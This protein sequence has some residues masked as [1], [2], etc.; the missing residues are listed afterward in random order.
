MRPWLLRALSVALALAAGC[1]QP[2]PVVA[3]P[4]AAG[5]G[6]LFTYPRDGQLDVPAGAWVVLHFS[7][8]LSAGAFDAGCTRGDAGVVGA[9][10]VEGPSGLIGS[11]ATLTGSSIVFAPSG[12]LEPGATYRIHAGPT[13]LEGATNLPAAGPLLTFH[14]RH[15]RTVGGDAPRLLSLN[16][17]PPAA[18]APDAGAA[19]PLLDVAPLRMLFSEPLDE[20]TVDAQSVR[21][22]KL[23][24]AGGETAVPAGL[25]AHGVHLTL[26]P[27]VDLD[28]TAGYRLH[29][30]AALKDVGGEP[31]APVDLLLH[32]R[33]T[34]PADGGLYDVDLSVA[35]PYVAGGTS[36]DSALLPMRVN[37]S[38]TTAPLIGQNVLGVLAGGVHAQLGDP[39]AFGGPIPMVIRKGQRLDLSP[40]VIRFGGVLE[41]GLQTGS[42]HL[43]FSSDAV[44]F[45][46]RSPFRPGAQVPDDRAP[47]FVDLTMDSVLTSDDAAGNTL[48]AQT[49]MGVRLL[50]ISTSDTDQ[51]LVQQFGALELSTL[52]VG[53]APVNLALALR[54]GSKPVTTPLPAPKLT[55]VFPLNG[56][57]DFPADSRI[58]LN[59]SGPIEP[60]KLRAGTELSLTENGAAV[61]FSANADGAAVTIKP[62][63]RLADG[64]AI[65]LT[66]TGLTSLTGQA[67]TGAAGDPTNGVGALSFTTAPFSAANAAPVIVTA[68]S[69]GAPCPMTGGGPTTPGSCAGGQ[70]SDTGYVPFALASNLELVVA[71]SQPMNPAT[72]VQSST[73]GSG[74]LR[75]EHLAANGSCQAVVPG[76]LLPTDRGLRFIPSAPW[77]PGASY[78]LTLAG[79]ADDT[80]G[81]G[82]LCS[83]AGK[84]LNTDVLVGAGAGA[85][86]GPDMVLNFAGAAATTASYLP[87]MTAPFTDQNGNGVVDP[88]EVPTDENRVAMEISGTSGLISAASLNG[89]D[90]VPARPGQQSCAYLHADLPVLIG[91]VQPSCPIDGQGK[92]TT[93]AGPC[94]QVR[95][96]P[97]LILNTS[98][99]M[100]TT[101]AGFLPISDLPTGELVMRVREVGGPAYGY[102]LKES[103][104]AKPQ[105]VIQQ[106]VYIDAPDLKIASGLVSHD[107]KSKALTVTLKGPVDFLPDG[108]MH[109]GLRNL[110]DVTITVNVKALVSGTIQMTI[111]AG[112]MRVTL[113]GPLPR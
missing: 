101:A 107:L 34:A 25:I 10:C 28:A 37:T 55:S 33:R 79:G 58:E 43:T 31:I 22:A 94:L 6:V 65:K 81:A 9:F 2:A 87:F 97:S 66:F 53:E 75:I 48:A 24:A 98:L 93:G 104:S 51:L 16:D 52:G 106:N 26:D 5:P 18:F 4:P 45:L 111:P 102:I 84:P 14:T 56:A 72:L 80:C 30:G 39:A 54:T 86:G 113:V 91:A 23:D 17:A 85:G 64:A 19:L 92:A 82:E 110:A 77:T 27:D 67:V 112:E 49:L 8:P 76:T 74:G 69:P 32:P 7:G 108:R 11:G 109:V 57:T 15:A 78:R 50:G 38:D 35:P 88:G 89:P 100:N 60:T 68:I 13:L 20:A 21:L 12:G 1:T 29:L 46:T 96:L 95:V 90:C 3:P 83:R 41:S 59:F 99:S 61:A 36:P 63:R 47:V 44:G 71:F 40:L 105:F 42:I 73:C 62:A 70:G 103:G